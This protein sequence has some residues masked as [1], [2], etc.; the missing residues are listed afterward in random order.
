MIQKLKRAEVDIWTCFLVETHILIKRISTLESLIDR[1]SR[2]REPDCNKQGLKSIR[3]KYAWVL[4][5]W[6]VE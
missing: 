2:R 6:N 3:K 1:A 4:E 5:L